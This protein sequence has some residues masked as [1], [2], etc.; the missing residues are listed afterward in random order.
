MLVVYI[1]AKSKWASPEIV[2]Q[3]SGLLLTYF[4]LVSSPHS[5]T[6]GFQVDN[7]FPVHSNLLN[8]YYGSG[9][10]LGARDT[11][12]DAGVRIKSGRFIT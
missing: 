1:E 5:L 11:V 6:L 12:L 3:Y 9:I 2:N 7:F 10:F 4:F 8:I